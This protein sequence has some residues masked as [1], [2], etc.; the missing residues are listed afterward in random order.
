[1]TAH[2]TDVHPGQDFD[3]DVEFDR[4][5]QRLLDKD[6]PAIAGLARDAFRNLV[7]PLHQAVLDRKAEFAAPTRARVPFVLVITRLVPAAAAMAVTELRGKPGFVTDGFDDV[8]RFSPI[9]SVEIPDGGAYVLFDVDRG[10]EYRNV[11]PDEALASITAAGRTP[12]TV[13]EGIAFVTQFPESLEKNNC[14]SLLAS[15]GSD[16]RVAALWI[17]KAMPKLGW[18]WDRNPHTWLGSASAACRLGPPGLSA[19]SE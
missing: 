12:L 18:C 17:S 1:M 7:T 13:D 15:R 8:D 14:F 6:Y 11:R 16:Q 5:V 3:A 19:A 9:D 4:Q 10:A 2:Q